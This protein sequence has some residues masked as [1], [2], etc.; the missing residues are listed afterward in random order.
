MTGYLKI[1]VCALLI[2]FAVPARAQGGGAAE[3]KILPPELPWS[4]ESR[5]L[6]A[7]ADDPWIT[8]AEAAGLER[9]PGY[10]E[11]FEWLRRLV[12]AA[13][14]LEMITLGESGQG[15]DVWMVIA[16][17]DGAFTPGALKRTGKPLILA[18]AGIHSGEIDGKDA[19]LMLLRDLT[20]GGEK[21]ELLEG[22]SLLFVPILN[23]D[24]H[25]R[26]SPHSRMNQ[27]GPERPGWRTNSRNLNLNRDYAKLDTREVRAVAK[28]I[29]SYEPDLYVDLHVTDG[30]DYQYD[31][32]WGSS[33]PHSWSPKIGTWFEEVLRPRLSADL[34]A[35]GHVPGPL[36]FAIEPKDPT[37]GLW[38]W[39]AGPRYSDGWGAA[40]HLPTILVE[41]HSLKPY[42]QRV[43]GTY[44][45]L[46]SLLRHV[47]EEAETLRAATVADRARRPE[48][49]P[50][51]F[52]V[53][54]DGEVETMDFLGVEWEIE[55][56]KITGE[57]LVVWAGEPRQL[58][59]PW[60]SPTR[61]GL[62][63]SRPEA[64]WIGPQWREV[65]ERL[66]LQGIEI[67]RIS[68]PR[69]LEVEMYRLGEVGID[70]DPFEG[71]VRVS[72]LPTIERRREHFPAGSVRIS[73]DQPLG[74]LAMLLLEPASPDSFFQWGF[75]LEVLQRTEYFE[76]Y[77][78]EPM[79]RKMLEE[80]QEL[81]AEFEKRLAEDEEF[82]ADPRARLEFFYRRT[83]FYDAR[84]N[85]YPVAREIAREAGK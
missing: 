80:D 51:T 35:A 69:E 38:N 75:F 83:P 20:V 31:I 7:E 19:G 62:T 15:R 32:T 64:Y 27:R 70:P 66:E 79:A 85:L 56:S 34:E 65:I 60:I 6:V 39:T 2:V 22:A 63:A 13:P 53:P 54:G 61:P 40:R 84:H 1:A 74:D 25:E 59:V 47:A 77:V 21:R 5:E 50:L 55:V 23:V 12:T 24:G 36:I 9:T 17:A 16:S 37:R 68:E 18:H 28:A 11:T 81:A 8:P 52:I 26:R 14:E 33:G 72:V 4:G 44:V 76:A 29:E 57:E 67:E 73:T 42:P 43:L 41:N 49:L 3:T 71:R 46:E 45:F 58:E 30:L 82:A 78:L 10:E 48:V